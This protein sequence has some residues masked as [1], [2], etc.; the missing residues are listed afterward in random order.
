MIL[1]FDYDFYFFQKYCG[2][3]FILIEGGIVCE[4]GVVLL[5]KK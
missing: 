4:D 3:Y 2:V 1:T 5:H